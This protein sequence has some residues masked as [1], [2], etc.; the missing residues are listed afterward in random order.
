VGIVEE[1]LVT[2]FIKKKAPTV[3]YFLLANIGKKKNYTRQV[4]IA[5]QIVPCGLATI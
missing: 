2:P 5:K 1:P 3:H 4:D